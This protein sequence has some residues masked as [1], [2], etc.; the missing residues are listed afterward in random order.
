MRVLG[1]I[2][3]LF[4]VLPFGLIYG[5]KGDSHPKITSAVILAAPPTKTFVGV[6]TKK[7]NIRVTLKWVHE[8]APLRT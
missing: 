5:P 4:W 6:S 2:K 3:I 8:F 7:N 1:H